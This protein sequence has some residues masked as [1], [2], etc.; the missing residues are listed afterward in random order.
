M[1]VWNDAAGVKT[2]RL[3]QLSNNLFLASSSR[4]TCMG[5]DL[6]IILSEVLD[7]S[8]DHLLTILGHFDYCDLRCASLLLELEELNVRHSMD[9]VI[10]LAGLLLLGSS[11]ILLHWLFS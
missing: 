9:V 6:A 8:M 3:V 1:E 4:H 5:S 11:H 2:A 7:F 10:R